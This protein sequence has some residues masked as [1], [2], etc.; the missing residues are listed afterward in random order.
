M[1]VTG[2]ATYAIKPE[3]KYFSCWSAVL[4]CKARSSSMVSRFDHPDRDVVTIPAGAK[5]LKI[6]VRDPHLRQAGFITRSPRVTRATICLPGRDPSSWFPSC[7]E[8][9]ASG[10][11]A[12]LSGREAGEP[13]S[14]MFDSSSGD[15][16][17]WVYL[18]D[19][20]KKPARLDWAPQAELIEEVRQLDRYD[21]E[22]ETLAGFEKLWESAAIVGSG[23]RKGCRGRGRTSTG[24]LSK[25]RFSSDR[26]PPDRL[27]LA[28]LAG[29]PS[30][31]RLGESAASFRFRQPVLTGS[32]AMTGPGGYVLLD[33]QLIATFR[34]A[35]IG[36]TFRDGN[37]KRTTSHRVLAIW[38]HGA[39]RLGRAVVEGSDQQGF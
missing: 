25:A 32:S 8:Q 39:G 5:T 22:L 3:Y 29:F 14:I 10:S 38:P 31:Q 16:D 23:V 37:R 28:Q 24:D 12:A 21:P 19:Q 27:N 7:I 4:P 20:A 18:V 34:G 15:E 6:E 1:R 26:K 9:A 13:M 2:S 11:V 30:R 35:K 33:G 17:Y 36:A